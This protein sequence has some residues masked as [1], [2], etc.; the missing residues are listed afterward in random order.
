MAKIDPE[1][2]CPCESGLL[3][4]ECHGPRV[5]IMKAP[6]IT[7]RIALG[8]IPEPD[9]N[10]RAIFFYEGEGTVVF[11][12]YDVGLALT[13]GKCASELVTGVRRDAIQGVVIRCK[14]C[15]AFNEV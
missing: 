15:G 7:H 12:G 2:R 10:S 5:K 8:V 11:S 14:N 1:E 9:P 6:A 4:K 13:C 3:F